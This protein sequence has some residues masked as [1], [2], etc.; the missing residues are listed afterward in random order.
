MFNKYVFVYRTFMSV[1]DYNKDSDKLTKSNFILHVIIRDNA[2]INWMLMLE[3][4]RQAYALVNEIQLKF[5]ISFVS[6][7]KRDNLSRTVV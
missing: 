4:F 3:Q 6:N 7:C 1:P 5:I 2:R